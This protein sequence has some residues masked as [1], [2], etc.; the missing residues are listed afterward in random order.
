M[1]F[2]AVVLVAFLFGIASAPLAL[3]LGLSPALVAVGVAAGCGGFRRHRGRRALAH[4]RPTGRSP[5]G[6]AGLCRTRG[7]LDVATGRNPDQ[8]SGEH[9]TVVIDRATSILDRLGLP[10]TGLVGPPLGRWTLPI[11]GVALDVDRRRLLAWHLAGVAT[12][13]TVLV[14][15]FD[16]LITALR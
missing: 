1:E 15:G 13:S 6:L 10:G 8:G 2:L 11:A 3:A 16:Q 14:V 5:S 9:A 12:W 4:A 7:R